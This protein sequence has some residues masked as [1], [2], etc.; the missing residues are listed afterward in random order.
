VIGLFWRPGAA[1][2]TLALAISPACGAERRQWNYELKCRPIVDVTLRTEL[3]LCAAS[4]GCR[5]FQNAMRSCE[6]AR[7]FFDRLK[8]VL[9]AR[10]RTTHPD[11]DALG[12]A[13][14]SARLKQLVVSNA[15]IFEAGLPAPVANRGIAANDQAM[16]SVLARWKTLHR[17]EASL[18]LPDGGYYEGGVK[19]GKP[20]GVGVL[21]WP[22]SGEVTRAQFVDGKASGQGQVIFPDGNKGTG[23]LTTDPKTGF[24]VLDG[25][26]AVQ[27]A[28]PGAKAIAGKFRM[29]AMIGLLEITEQ[30]G[31]TRL[32]FND[33]KGNRVNWG[34][35]FADGEQPVPPEVPERYL[36]LPTEPGWIPRAEVQ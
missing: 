26:G 20:D 6:P 36:P 31:R 1:F 28:G 22:E 35:P 34:K 2:A 8:S 25:P 32:S 33:D 18:T 29:S 3:D 4:V 14:K 17:E 5:M 19:D 9:E 23:W 21:V 10:S 12:P 24:V 30:D 13:D 11:Y 27:F 16:V 15:D 7:K